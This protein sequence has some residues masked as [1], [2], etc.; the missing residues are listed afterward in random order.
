MA[1]GTLTIGGSTYHFTSTGVWIGYQAPAGYLQPVSQTTSLGWATN[2]LTWGMN[3]V[4]VRIVQQR[5]GLW[6]STKLASVDA[7]FQNAVRNFQR[8]VGLPQTG[9]V[10][11]STW[12]AL[13]TGYSWWVDQYQATPVSLSAT[14]SERIEAMIGYARDQLGSSYTWGGAG[15]YNLG[16]DCSGLSLQSL[17]R[18][19]TPSRSTCTSTPGPRTAR[20]RSSTT[21]P[22]SCTCR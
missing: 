9:V 20:P 22:A 12:N 19:W 10:D 21:T 7:S 18:A 17:Y 1:T 2:D 16:F 13:D 11:Q 6:Y 4:K 8:R 15:P 3:G 5:L 14:R